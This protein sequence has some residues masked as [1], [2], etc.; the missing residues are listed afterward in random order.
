MSVVNKLPLEI[1]HPLKIHDNKSCKST[2]HPGSKLQTNFERQ[3]CDNYILM[4]SS[5]IRSVTDVLSFVVKWNWVL[6]WKLQRMQGLQ[7]CT[8]SIRKVTE[9]KSSFWF[10]LMKWLLVWRQ[11]MELHATLAINKRWLD[12]SFYSRLFQCYKDLH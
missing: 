12:L 11:K 2:H 5:K 10:L 7:I 8:E 3:S 9:T 1:F 4:H 6:L